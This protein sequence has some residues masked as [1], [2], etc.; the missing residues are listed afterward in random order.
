MFKETEFR[1]S[2]FFKQAEKCDRH[3]Q[4][5]LEDNLL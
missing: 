1:S 5:Q 4:E 2:K 3:H